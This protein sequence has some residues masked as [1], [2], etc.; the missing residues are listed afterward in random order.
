MTHS[1]LHVITT[2]ELGGAEKQLLTLAS[3]QREQGFDVEVL[4]LKGS[5]TLL[6]SFLEADVKV[7][8][9]YVGLGFFEQIL[10]FRNRKSHINLVIHAHLPRAELLCA[11]SSKKKGFLVTRHNAEP[12]FPAAPALLSK[13][14]SRLVLSRAYSCISIS[15]AVKTYLISS[16]EMN[17]LQNNCVI[18][19]G[20]SRTNVFPGKKR[21]NNSEQ[22]KLGTVSRLV[23]QKNLPLLLETLRELNTSS[24]RSFELAVVGSGP[25][26]LDLQSLSISLGVEGVVSWLG[27][28]EDVIAF[29]SSLDFFIL[30]SNYEGFGLV[31]LEAMSQGIPVIARKISAI[32]EVMGNEHP[33]LVDSDNPLDLARKLLE[34]VD[35]KLILNSCLDYQRMRLQEFPISKTQMQHELLY[36]RLLTQDGKDLNDGFDE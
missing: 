8:L 10:K 19:Y 29:Y 28:S 26:R 24:S 4:F 13:F 27:Q 18:Y 23:P 16:G 21:D 2:I 35:N 17:S 12:F 1:I 36:S 7:D 33:G 25:Q 9:G 30:S 15:K 34:F 20:L 11:I 32:P 3:Y 6:E 14:L 22:I 5:P 31:L